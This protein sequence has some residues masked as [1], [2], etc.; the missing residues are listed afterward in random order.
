[1]AWVFDPTEGAIRFERIS[2][3]PTGTDLCTRFVYRLKIIN[4]AILTL[5]GDACMVIVNGAIAQ[6]STLS[7][8]LDLGL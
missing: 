2:A 1:M 4:P 5:H 8:D 6:Q 3:A 7:G